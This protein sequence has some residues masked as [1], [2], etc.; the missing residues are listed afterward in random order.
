M[1]LV[2]K[3]RTLIC[4]GPNAGGNTEEHVE[5]VRTELS[6]ISWNISPSIPGKLQNAEFVP[7]ISKYDL[8]CLCECWIKLD[9]QTYK[10]LE[11]YMINTFDSVVCTVSTLNVKLLFLNFV[12][13][14][15]KTLTFYE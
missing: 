9:D 2:T 4:S 7:M 10:Y 13:F 12:I 14:H 1:R 11:G 15:Q 5:S 6:L 8:I 3:K